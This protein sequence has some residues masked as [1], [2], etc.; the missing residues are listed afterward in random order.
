MVTIFMLN[1]LVFQN[2]SFSTPIIFSVKSEMVSFILIG[3]KTRVPKCCV[4]KKKTAASA[5]LGSIMLAIIFI[6]KSIMI[7]I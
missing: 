4:T 3:K 2:L 6:K 7:F 1:C 5:S